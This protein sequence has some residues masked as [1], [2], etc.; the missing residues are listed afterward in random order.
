MFP[1]DE[2]TEE[3][4][5]SS[6]LQQ[7]SFNKLCL[8]QKKGG[9]STTKSTVGKDTG[10]AVV[11]RK[12]NRVISPNH[13]IVRRERVKVKKSR[14]PTKRRWSRAWS[15]KSDSLAE[16]RRFPERR[17]RESVESRL[18]RI[19]KKHKGVSGGKNSQREPG[20]SRF[21]YKSGK[22]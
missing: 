3:L 10:A 14:T 6:R 9:L 1:A 21:C 5:K 8:P 12:R 15:G 13:K 11:E 7:K 19:R 20:K 2:T 16:R 18:E 17:G 4:A 22:T